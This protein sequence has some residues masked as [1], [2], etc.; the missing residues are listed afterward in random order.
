VV[1]LKFDSLDHL[2]WRIRVLLVFPFLFLQ[3]DLYIF[4]F[5]QISDCW[6]S[7]SPTN[8]EWLYRSFSVKKDWQENMEIETSMAEELQSKPIG[9]LETRLKEVEADLVEHRALEQLIAAGLREAKCKHDASKYLIE[10][11]QKQ[12]AGFKGQIQAREKTHGQ[13]LEKI[14]SWLST[15]RESLT[16]LKKEKTESEYDV[17]AEATRIEHLTALL[18][19]RIDQLQADLVDAQIVRDDLTEVMKENDLV[20]VWTSR[21]EMI[22]QLLYGNVEPKGVKLIKQLTGSTTSKFIEELAA[23]YEA[24][25]P[26]QI[27]AKDENTAQPKP[28]RHRSTELSSLLE[29]SKYEPSPS[30]PVKQPMFQASATNELDSPPPKPLTRSSCV[31]PRAARSADVLNEGEKDDASIISRS[32]A[33]SSSISN[34][35]RANQSISEPNS[36]NKKEEK[37][38]SKKKRTQGADETP[39]QPSGKKVK[40]KVS[41][42][43]GKQPKGEKATRPNVD[44]GA[45][46]AKTKAVAA[47]KQNEEEDT[48]QAPKKLHW[49]QLIKMKRKEREDKD[50]SK[51]T[52]SACWD[53]TDK[54]DIILCDRCDLGFHLTC[55][56]HAAIPRTWFICKTCK[57]ESAKQAKV[58]RQ[59][60]SEKHHEKMKAS[61]EKSLPQLSKESPSHAKQ[62]QKKAVTA[63]STD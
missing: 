20:H 34:G 13:E 22:N 2:F 47:K 19:Y 59:V 8:Q 36:S 33:A 37:P 56:G 48:N 57:I 63:P 31:Q 42:D 58:V 51:V 15:A 40:S 16:I 26:L 5:G 4:F 17:A 49:T 35:V 30:V 61:A 10:R 11:M 32:S 53:L 27:K 39:P 60:W 28:K 24:S 23:K 29:A 12:I 43:G 7:F 18:T 50:Y 6:L 1:R 46:T 44:D 14:Q 38:P 21:V 62:K 55:A 54:E 41:S 9:E 25:L 3:G 52:C 45:T